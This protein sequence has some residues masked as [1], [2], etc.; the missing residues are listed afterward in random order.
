[1]NGSMNFVVYSLGYSFNSYSTISFFEI[2]L[3]KFSGIVAQSRSKVFLPYQGLFDDSEKAR[4]R[5]LDKLAAVFDPE[6]VD[7]S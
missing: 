3:W 6:Y 7:N 2:F 5:P 4:V 1:M